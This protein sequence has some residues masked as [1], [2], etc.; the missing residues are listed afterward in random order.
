MDFVSAIK[1]GFQKYATF[2]RRASRSEF[3]F[4]VLFSIVV[5]AAGGIIDQALF[6]DANVELFAPLI[7]LA[8][9]VPFLA[10]WAR[11]LHDSDRNGWWLLI[12]YSGIGIILLIV[13]Y[14]SKGTVGTNRFGAD[15]LSTEAVGT[16]P[17]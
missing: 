6:R 8:L 10:V 14:C 3:W 12:Y 7:V 13:W 15:P 17:F 11:R 1:S 5:T 2:S 16:G 9:L 4:W